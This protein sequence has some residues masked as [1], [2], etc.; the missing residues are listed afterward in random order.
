MIKTLQIIQNLLWNDRNGQ[1]A[2]K[3]EIWSKTSK[4][5]KDTKKC[6]GMIFM[7]NNQKTYP[8]DKKQAF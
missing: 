6:L 3:T 5:L 2:Q 8:F 4:I 7:A 1:N